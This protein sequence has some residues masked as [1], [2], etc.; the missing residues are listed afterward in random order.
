MKIKELISKLNEV[1]DE[2]GNVEVL[3]SDSGTEMFESIVEFDLYEYTED[4]P[5]EKWVN[6][7]SA[8][9]IEKTY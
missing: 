7:I 3:I 9:F 4:T 6:L 5:H 8:E 2:H 1:L